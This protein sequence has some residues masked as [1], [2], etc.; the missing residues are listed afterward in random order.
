MSVCLS[1]Y[2]SVSMT[3]SL[4]CPVVPRWQSLSVCLSVCLSGCLSV[5]L[6][7]CLSGCLCLSVRLSVCVCLSGCLS[8]CLSGCLCLSVRLSV[9]LSVRLSVSVCPAVC[10]VLSVS[11]LTVPRRAG[12]RRPLQV[13]AVSGGVGETDGEM[14][15]SHTVS[16]RQRTVETVTVRARRTTSRPGQEHRPRYLCTDRRVA[17]GSVPCELR[18]NLPCPA[19][20]APVLLTR[21]CSDTAALLTSAVCGKISVIL[22]LMVSSGK[23]TLKMRSESGKLSTAGCHLPPKSANFWDSAPQRMIR[24]GFSV[25]CMLSWKSSLFVFYL[26]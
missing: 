17:V 21:H 25:L 18:P 15:S 5:C 22:V 4:K 11:V 7:V 12:G 19:P 26:R 13:S 24:T 16:S 8:V 20:A 14:V 2:M 1:V 23:F 9:C 10:G 6:S 3:L